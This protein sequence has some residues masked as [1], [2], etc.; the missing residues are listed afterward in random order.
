MRSANDIHVQHNNTKNE[1]K[2]MRA[3]TFVLPNEKAD[4]GTAVV[5]S[6]TP[7]KPY[8]VSQAK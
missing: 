1:K 5:Y 4:H 3:V 8:G 2:K 7:N 6:D